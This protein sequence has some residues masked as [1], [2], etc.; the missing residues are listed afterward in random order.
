M[1]TKLCLGSVFRAP[2]SALAILL[3][4]LLSCPLLA[5]SYRGG[6]YDGVD[7]YA[8]P[9]R[10][11]HP[12]VINLAATNVI[13]SS[14]F[15]NGM[16]LSTGT[17]DT[18]VYA[19]WGTTDGGTNQGSWSN[20]V[21]FGVC[22]ECQTLTTNVS[23]NANTTYFYRFYA[24]N[25]AGDDA[26][27]VASASLTPPGP[28]VVGTGMGAM[29]VG[30]SSA[31]LNANLVLGGTATVTIYWGATTNSW[32]NTNSVG[33]LSQGRAAH[34]AVSGL[35]PASVYYYRGYGTNTYGEGWSGVTSF[36]T[37]VS[38]AVSCG[39]PYDGYDSHRKGCS[40]S[41]LA[42]TVFSVY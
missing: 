30:F 22:P 26:W 41:R 5:Q 39:G 7:R 9:C 29:P 34:V 18:A 40:V 28:P 23:V 17:A 11:G 20:A 3:F 15:L 24:T 35:T 4:L 32:A 31:G 10:M 37:T 36:T 14:V 25:A 1:T 6:R 21:D 12:V 33:S 2:R 8:A 13:P 16:L 19:Y 42:G 27:A 38:L